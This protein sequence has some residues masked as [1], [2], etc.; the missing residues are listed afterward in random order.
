V[1]ATTQ[2]DRLIGHIARDSTAIPARERY[3]ETLQQ[4]KQ[5]AAKSRKKK[6]G[7]GSFAKKKATERGTRI[8]RQRKQK[9]AQMLSDL[10]S[11]CDSGA[12][13]NSKGQEQYWRSYKLHVDV[14]DGQVPI[15]AVLTSASV[16]DSHKWRSH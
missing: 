10:P 12:K 3:P 7:K 9:V 16:H 4:Q 5:K 13:K 6:H 1:V 8:E 15:S 2:K 14:A 11:P